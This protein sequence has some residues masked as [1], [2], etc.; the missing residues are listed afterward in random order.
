MAKLHLS[1]PW[2]IFCREIEELFKHDEDVHVVYDEAEDHVKLYVDD[3]YKAAA[4][5]QLLPKEKVFGSVKL[6][7]SVVPSNPGIEEGYDFTDAL[8]EDIFDAIFIRNDAFSFAKTISGI[9]PSNLTYVVFKKRVVQYF[10]DDLGDAF[11][12]CST[13]YQEIAKDVFG[14]LDGVFF[15]T[16]KKD[17]DTSSETM[18]DEWP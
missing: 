4:I 12:Q 9:F 17:D 5:I 15:C 10:N 8:N 6:R 18:M 11:G 13:L 16:D 2:V 1:A 7:I 14:E 3:G